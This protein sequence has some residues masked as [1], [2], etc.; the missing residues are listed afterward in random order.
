MPDK[1]N[2]RTHEPKIRELTTDLD[3]F[4]ELMDERDRRYESKYQKVEKKI[5]EIKKEITRL[6]EKRREN[7]GVREVTHESK[8]QNQWVIALIIGGCLGIADIVVRLLIKG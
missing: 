2:G 7:L 1:D 6:R 8:Q 5:N 3:G 4:K